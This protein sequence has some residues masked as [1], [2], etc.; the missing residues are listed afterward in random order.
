ML[1]FIFNHTY[2]VLMVNKEIK[3][4]DEMTNAYTLNIINDDPFDQKLVIDIDLK[5]INEQIVTGILYKDL[6]EKGLKFSDL[7]GAEIYVEE[8]KTKTKVLTYNVI[9]TVHGLFKIGVKKYRYDG[10]FKGY[11]NYAFNPKDNLRTGWNNNIHKEWLGW[12]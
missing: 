8:T 6:K 4:G 2:T 11:K 3:K 5:Y 10:L 9:S 7:E 12:V 1:V